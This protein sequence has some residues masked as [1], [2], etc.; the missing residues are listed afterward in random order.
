MRDAEARRNASRMMNSSMR[1]SLTGLT[2][3]LDEEDVVAAHRL[4][5]L[6][7]EFAVGEASDLDTRQA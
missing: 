1:L 6:D 2:R 4:A 3:R 7:V 5:D